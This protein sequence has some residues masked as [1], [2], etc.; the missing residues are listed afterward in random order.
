MMTMRNKQ[1]DPGGDR[2]HRREERKK[3]HKEQLPG[4]DDQP[5]PPPTEPIRSDG[6]PKRNDPCTCGSGKKYKQCCGKAGG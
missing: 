6:Q 2:F 1:P 3:K 4:G 5:L